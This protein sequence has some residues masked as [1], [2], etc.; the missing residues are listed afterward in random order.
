MF[1]GSCRDGGERVSQG[2]GTALFKYHRV[3]CGDRGP[4]T[5]RLCGLPTLGRR[6]MKRTPKGRIL[7]VK[8]G[9][10]DTGLD[11]TTWLET[12]KALRRAGYEV[13]LVT[14]YERVLVEFPDWR[15]GSI[16]WP[17]ATDEV[18]EAGCFQRQSLAGGCEVLLEAASRLRPGVG[19]NVCDGLPLRRSSASWFSRSKDRHGFSHVRVRRLRR[20]V[21]RHDISVDHPSGVCLRP[22]WTLRGDGDQPQT[23]QSGRGNGRSPQDG[24]MGVG[25]VC[26]NQ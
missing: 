21:A 14:S 17:T 2:G 9:T 22:S 18:R 20:W 10:L 26:P 6:S 7:W 4:G 8:S 12:G 15:D 16:V 13:T 5:R 24:H 25:V 19:A 23:R 3:F 1:S 11:R